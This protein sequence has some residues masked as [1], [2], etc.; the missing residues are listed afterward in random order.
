MDYI[1]KIDAQVVELRWTSSEAIS[2]YITDVNDQDDNYLVLK[3]VWS[4]YV[5]VVSINTV[6]R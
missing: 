1:I 4:Y 2:V 6:D 3:D 5:S